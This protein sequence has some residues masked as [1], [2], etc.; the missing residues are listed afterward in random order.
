MFTGGVSERELDQEGVGESLAALGPRIK[1]A[2]IIL[3][4][5]ANVLTVNAMLTWLMPVRVFSHLTPRDGS[6]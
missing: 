3:G 1:S 2:P 6:E 5:I 4:V